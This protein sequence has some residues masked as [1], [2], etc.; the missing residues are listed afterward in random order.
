MIVKFKYKMKHYGFC[1]CG[2]PLLDLRRCQLRGEVDHPITD[3]FL[4]L[5]LSLCGAWLRH[6]NSHICVMKSIVMVKWVVLWRWPPPAHLVVRSLAAEAGGSFR[7]HGKSHVT[8]IAPSP[9]SWLITVALL[10]AE[11]IVN[12]SKPGVARANITAA[13]CGT[14]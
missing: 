13:L 11:G 14:A 5:T 10:D 9:G 3:P 8:P 7:G 6:S 1:G 2:V 12:D 4:L